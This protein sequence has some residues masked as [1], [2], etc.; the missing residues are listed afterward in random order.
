MPKIY[1][2]HDFTGD[3]ETT[4]DLETLADFC[5]INFDPDMKQAFLWIDDEVVR[6][7]HG[8]AFIAWDEAPTMQWGFL[9]LNRSGSPS[10]NRR[11]AGQSARPR[12]DLFPL[13]RA[14]HKL[15]GG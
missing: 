9:T 4:G 10:S 1:F 6:P 5:C 12:V 7:N 11:M 3:V 15:R 8:R 14:L 13:P 2:A